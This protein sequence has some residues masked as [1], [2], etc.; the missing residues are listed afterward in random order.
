[1]RS[2]LLIEVVNQWGIDQTYPIEQAL[3]KIVTKAS[4]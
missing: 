2:W 1:M 3:F 4:V